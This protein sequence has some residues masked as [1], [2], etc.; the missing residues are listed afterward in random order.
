MNNPSQQMK[1]MARTLFKAKAGSN[2]EKILHPNRDWF[3]GVVIAVCLVAGIAAWNGYI[4]FSNR[5]GGATDTEIIVANP[6]YQ[7]ELVDQALSIFESRSKNFLIISANS[8]LQPVQTETVPTIETSA[9]PTTSTPD[10]LV[11]I[12]PS[13]G[14]EGSADTQT[15]EADTIEGNPS[16]PVDGL[17]T[18]ELSQ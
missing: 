6:R 5:D 8:S 18:P 14:A 11:D 16:A 12:S 10:V 15:T 13:V 7:A 3:I 4:Y 1:Q 17:G 2:Y 9:T